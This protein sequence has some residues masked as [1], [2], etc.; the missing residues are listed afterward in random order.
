VV[1]RVCTFV[2]LA[3]SR[4]QAKRRQRPV[5]GPGTERRCHR[6]L[7]LGVPVLGQRRRAARPR[8]TARCWPDRSRWPGGRLIPGSAGTGSAWVRGGR[9][10]RQRQGNADEPGSAGAHG[11]DAAASRF[12]GEPTGRVRAVV[13]RPRRSVPSAAWPAG[14]LLR[15]ENGRCAGC[16]P[17]RGCRGC[18]AMTG[19]TRFL[20]RPVSS[21]NHGG[22]AAIFSI[23]SFAVVRLGGHL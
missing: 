16:W 11:H 6:P 22:E 9:A 2:V 7:A 13:H 20:P 5:L 23:D 12:A 19:R 4:A 15:P 8:C 21:A 3:V 1:A 18:G 17:E 10:G 14:S